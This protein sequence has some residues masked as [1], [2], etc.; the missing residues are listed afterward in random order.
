MSNFTDKATVDLFVNGEQPKQ[1]ID[2]LTKQLEE[3]KTRLVEAD[4]AGDL[5][6]SKSLQ[7]QIEQTEK[8]LQPESGLSSM[9]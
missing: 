2:R 7:K 6:A 1:E 4:K 3:Y 8:Q 5:K 9:I